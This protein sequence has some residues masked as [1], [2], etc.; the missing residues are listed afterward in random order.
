M[1]WDAAHDTEQQTLD[2]ERQKINKYVFQLKQ[3]TG[4]GSLRVMQRTG[5]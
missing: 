3:D 1:S 2:K 5:G 4:K